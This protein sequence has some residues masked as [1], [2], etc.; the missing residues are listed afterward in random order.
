MT[1]RTSTSVYRMAFFQ[2]MPHEEHPE[3]LVGHEV[4]WFDKNSD[5]QIR[6]TVDHWN[7]YA[8]HYEVRGHK[9]ERFYILTPDEVWPVYMGA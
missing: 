8:N 5:V 4:Y 1:F 2:R 9:T 7:E 6:G 3:S